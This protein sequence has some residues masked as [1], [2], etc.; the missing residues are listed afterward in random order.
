MTV[1]RHGTEVPVPL[2][3]GRMGA[4]TRCLL[5]KLGQVIFRLLEGE[6]AELGLRIRHYSVIGSLLDRGPMSQQ[7]ICGYLRI[8]SATMVATI[9][10]LERL[11]LVQRKRRDG[12][13]RSYV[14]SITPEGEQ[15]T[16]RIDR[17]MQRLDDE[18]L[19][20]ITGPQRRQLSHVAGKLS[21][22]P[23]LTAAYDGIRGS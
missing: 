22:G 11:G 5:Q 7:D 14:V 23:T 21:A 12:D 3:P 1:G 20:D 13:R 2:V 9:D 8:D 17:L 6:L 16:E 18:L 10:D 15:A 4:H 19:A